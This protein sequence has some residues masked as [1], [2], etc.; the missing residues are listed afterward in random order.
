MN[1]TVI[2]E[3]IKCGGCARSISS[4]LG[5]I[6]GVSGVTVDVARG[7]V[8]FSAGDEGREAAVRRLKEMG[9]PQPG[10]ASGLGSAV[11]TARSFVSCAAG[12]M[13]GMA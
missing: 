1:W 2:V 11:A 7:S 10:T 9:Y 4:G 12:K 13:A 3:N 6:E 5:A 8:S